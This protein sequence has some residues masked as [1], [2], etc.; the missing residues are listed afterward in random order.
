MY[1]Y[2][3]INNYM[4]KQYLLKRYLHTFWCISIPEEVSTDNRFDRNL[5]SS[6]S[7]FTVIDH[8]TVVKHC[9]A[10]H[11]LVTGSIEQLYLTGGQDQ[12][13]SQ[14]LLI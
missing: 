6:V 12:I 14:H 9:L 3:K 10:A 2:S 4:Y 11:S 8:C 5:R 7:I 13:K 1:T